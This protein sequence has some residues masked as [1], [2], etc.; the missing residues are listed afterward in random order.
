M[1]NNNSILSTLTVLLCLQLSAP[2]PWGFYRVHKTSHKD[3]MLYFHFLKTL[4]TRYVTRY[5][6]GH[7]VHWPGNVAS[8]KQSPY[9]SNCAEATE[10]KKGSRRLRLF[11]QQVD[12]LFYA[13][14]EQHRLIEREKDQKIGEGEREGERGSRPIGCVNIRLMVCEVHVFNELNRLV[15]YLCNN[16][17]FIKG[18]K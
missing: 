13:V 11:K 16:E 1:I 5:V 14:F 2:R 8:D 7:S 12:G 9:W 10:R 3:H 6:T 17:V 18:V 15:L 4:S